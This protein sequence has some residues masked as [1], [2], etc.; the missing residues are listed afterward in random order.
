MMGV[1]VNV[2]TRKSNSLCMCLHV[3]ACMDT[4]CSSV[5]I[6][7][8]SVHVRYA[9]ALYVCECVYVFFSALLNMVLNKPASRFMWNWNHMKFSNKWIVNRVSEITHHSIP[10]YGHLRKFENELVFWNKFDTLTLSH[11]NSII[12]LTCKIKNCWYD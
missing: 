2:F 10:F 3:F 6:C 11:T 4:H 5:C 9:C 7:E 12:Y 1:F 8:C